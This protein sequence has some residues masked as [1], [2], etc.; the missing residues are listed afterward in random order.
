MFDSVFCLIIILV[1]EISHLGTLTGKARALNI[2][3]D[4]RVLGDVNGDG[5]VNHPDLFNIG[6]AY[7]STPS[8]S[9]WDSNC[10]LNRDYRVAVSDLFYLGKNYGKTG[11][12]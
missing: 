10:D 12:P 3:I 6:Q 7:G 5:K 4:W 2:L 11:S 1:L 8:Q 9:N